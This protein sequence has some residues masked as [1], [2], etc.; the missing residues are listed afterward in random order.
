VIEQPT[1]GQVITTVKASFLVPAAEFGVGRLSMLASE[2][3]Q[4]VGKY[5]ALRILSEF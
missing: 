5:R 4:L 2:F 1:G 3:G